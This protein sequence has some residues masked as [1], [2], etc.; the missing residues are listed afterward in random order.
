MTQNMFFCCSVEESL[1][2]EATFQKVFSC[3]FVLRVYGM[4]EGIPPNKTVKQKGIVMEFMTRGS[5]M[6]LCKNLQGPPPFPLACRLIQEVASGMRFLHSMGILHRDLK[7]Q[8]VMLCEDLHA[9]LADFGLCTTSVTYCPSIEEETEN[10]GT[11]K[12]MPPEA[13]DINYKPVR[14]YD[15]YSFAIFL[16]A[17]LSG[18][19]PFPTAHSSHLRKCVA[20]GQRPPLDE[21]SKT[22]KAGMSDLLDLMQKC[23]NG[24]PTQRPTFEEITPMVE[25]VYSKHKSKI[26]YAVCEVLNQLDSDSL[27]ASHNP[28]LDEKDKIH[29]QDSTICEPLQEEQREG[30]LTLTSETNNSPQ[31]PILDP[32]MG[33]KMSPFDAYTQGLISEFGPMLVGVDKK[34]QQL[35]SILPKSATPVNSARLH[36][37]NTDETYQTAGVMDTNTCITR[38]NATQ[39]RVIERTAAQ[40]LLEAQAFTSNI[41]I[42]NKVFTREED[43]SFYLHKAAESCQK[44]VESSRS[45]ME[46]QHLTGGLVNTT[47]GSRISSVS[48]YMSK[49]I[50]STMTRE[51]EAEMFDPKSG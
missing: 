30:N 40:R 31:I 15:V 17:I 29:K 5:I 45:N 49:M 11:V 36:F 23:W 32:E 39:L 34:Q 41:D 16:W 7:M 51:R 22:D 47:T 35:S 42:Q 20:K 43:S 33:K 48:A 3:K 37:S 6:D 10:S 44:L 9:K 4:Y 21:L 1:L 13:Y 25:N 18:E 8:N 12:Y 28:T 19:E 27:D 46:L 24:D 14:S 26:N 2:K 50:D 38:Q